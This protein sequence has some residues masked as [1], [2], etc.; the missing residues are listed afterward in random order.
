MKGHSGVLRKGR[1]QQHLGGECHGLSSRLS[2]FTSTMIAKRDAILIASRPPT[3]II[4]RTQPHDTYRLRFLAKA[5]PVPQQQNTTRPP[6]ANVCPYL[7]ILA[8]I[9]APQQF[10]LLPSTASTVTVVHIDI[11]RL[12]TFSREGH[13]TLP[14]EQA[15]WES[16]PCGRY[17]VRKSRHLI[18]PTPMF[19][20]GKRPLPPLSLHGPP[21]DEPN[22]SPFVLPAASLVQFHSVRQCAPRCPY[23]HHDLLSVL[24]F[25]SM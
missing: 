25:C 4:V 9:C 5:G 20:Q 17:E 21:I 10:V 13:T 16:C 2:R 15:A 1:E 3:A 11:S 18:S 7:P 23:T 24:L 12:P 14:R 6:A 19:A 22:V 8:L